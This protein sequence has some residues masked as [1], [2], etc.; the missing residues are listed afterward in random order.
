MTERLHLHRHLELP[1][2]LHSVSQAC[3]NASALQTEGWLW[4]QGWYLD[5]RHGWLLYEKCQDLPLGFSSRPLWKLTVPQVLGAQRRLRWQCQ[6]ELLTTWCEQDLS[7][8]PS[9]QDS[10]SW[11]HG[12]ACIPGTLLYLPM[13][14]ILYPWVTV[15]GVI[16]YCREHHGLEGLCDAPKF[17]QLA[18]WGLELRGPY[19]QPFCP[20][21]CRIS[22]VCSSRNVPLTILPGSTPAENDPRNQKQS[23]V[24]LLTSFPPN[25]PHAQSVTWHP[26]L[27][28]IFPDLHEVAL[29]LPLSTFLRQTFCPECSTYCPPLIHSSHWASAICQMPCYL[30]GISKWTNP[31]LQSS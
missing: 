20:P 5:L 22:R 7:E 2:P 29:S 31:C 17:T 8:D 3:K 27:P 6:S 23:S 1:A 14:C 18:D 4:T 10:A 24:C 21:A 16:L 26:F 12:P 25:H 9:G 13:T 30:L 11:L 15:I 28:V 19:S